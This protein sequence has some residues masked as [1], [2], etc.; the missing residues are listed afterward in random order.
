MPRHE[1]LRRLERLQ[2]LARLMDTAIRVPGLGIRFGAD[3]IIGLIPGVGDAAGGLIGLYMINEARK[4]GMP[5]SKLL[6]MAGN[7]GADAL[8]GAVPLLGDVFDVF[9][10]SHRRNLDIMMEHFA[11]DRAEFARDVTPPH[12]R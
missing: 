7:V 11:E 1:R 8:V 9:F 10:K 4:M 12:R 6:R 2:R 5:A 3:S